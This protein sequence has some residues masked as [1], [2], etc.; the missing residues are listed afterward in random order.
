[1]S[2]NRTPQLEAY[3]AKRAREYESQ[4]YAKAE[5]QD[6]LAW[7]R[8][9][10]PRLFAGRRVLEVACGTGYWTREIAR[11]AAH[12]TACDINEPVLEVAREKRLPPRRVRFAKADA[13]AP[14]PVCDRCDA[15][16]AGFWWSH[17]RRAEASR[18]LGVLREAL[19]PGAL[20]GI[21]DNRYVEGSSTPLSRRDAA[22]D[23]W[24]VR[25]L[26]SGETHEVLKNFPTPAELAEAARPHA[27]EAWL[28]ETAY[29]WLLVLRLK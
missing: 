14:G 21:L 9:R 10:V 23:T 20:V 24:Q 3:Y 6:E 7:A 18:W 4:V 2:P 27:R 12:V 26:L 16:F 22:G 11:R 15:A 1:V 29:Y 19:A 28:E 13:F 25:T 8:D 5:R 17:L